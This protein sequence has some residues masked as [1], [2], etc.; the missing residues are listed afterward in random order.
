[1][2]NFI[3]TWNIWLKNDHKIRSR[4]K[5]KVRG[6]CQCFEMK[7][8]LQFLSQELDCRGNNHEHHEHIYHN[9]HHS[10]CQISLGSFHSQ[11]RSSLDEQHSAFGLTLSADSTS[12]T[13]INHIVV[14]RK[15]WKASS[16]YC[17]WWTQKKQFFVNEVSGWIIS[18]NCRVYPEPVRDFFSGI[19]VKGHETPDTSWDNKKSISTVFHFAA[20]MKRI[21]HVWR[22][23]SAAWAVENDVKEEPMRFYW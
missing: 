1:M 11:L 4:W 16:K 8:M 6:A 23:F 18:S 22:L 13:F 14:K 12:R 21:F 10:P 3:S 9:R 2:Q 5:W 15:T 20:G 19:H 17:L 7:F